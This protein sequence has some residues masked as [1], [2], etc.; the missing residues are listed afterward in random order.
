MH[1]GV[2]DVSQQMLT[3]KKQKCAYMDVVK[4]QYYKNKMKWAN[5]DESAITC[6]VVSTYN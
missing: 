4:E 2:I 5:V 6:I 3:S 1:A